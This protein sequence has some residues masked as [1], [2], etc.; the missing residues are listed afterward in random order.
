MERG[1]LLLRKVLL[2]DLKSVSGIVCMT[3]AGLGILGL[4]T[5]SPSKG[6]LSL[7]QS[8]VQS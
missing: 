1:R 3:L 7:T 2:R 5:L 6:R 4:L 8:D